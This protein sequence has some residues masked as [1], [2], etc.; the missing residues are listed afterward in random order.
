VEFRGPEPLQ[1][2]MCTIFR[3]AVACG[4]CCCCSLAV[5]IGLAVLSAQ[6][7][8]S[9]LHTLVD[10]GQC[11]NDTLG[12]FSSDM[13]EGPCRQMEW[14]DCDAQNHSKAC[15]QL[16]GECSCFV[17]DRLVNDSALDHLNACCAKF[18]DFH[19][20]FLG[21]VVKKFVQ[22]CH[23]KMKEASEKVEEVHD[24]CTKGIYPESGD[25]IATPPM[26]LAALRPL[27][28]VDSAALGTPLLFA[29]AAAALVVG[30]AARLG[31]RRSGQ[32]ALAPLLGEEEVA[33]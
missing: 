30:A 31:R 13:R 3:A 14:E 24:N 21:G 23:K 10:A 20:P 2:K 12:N 29:A 32:G 28:L 8:A 22:E 1:C 5:F 26:D 33:A 15:E 16:Q 18:E 19:A 7:G 9:L 11:V 27:G 6:V 17:A 25:G 4:V